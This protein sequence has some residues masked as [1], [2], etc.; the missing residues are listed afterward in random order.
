[1]SMADE[2]ARLH[3]RKGNHD[4]MVISVNQSTEEASTGL[5]VLLE[6]SLSIDLATRSMVKYAKIR[7]AIDRWCLGGP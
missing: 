1:M 3:A 4:G 6:I 2:C 7:I 5:K